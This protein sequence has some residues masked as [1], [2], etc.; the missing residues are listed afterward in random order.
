MTQ[1]I[2]LIRIAM[3][4]LDPQ[5]QAATP[6]DLLAAAARII[7]QYQGPDHYLSEDLGDLPLFGSWE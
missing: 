5:W 1:A 4:R 2:D 6:Y 3:A 7:G